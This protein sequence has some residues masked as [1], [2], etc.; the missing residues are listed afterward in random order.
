MP[1]NLFS[2]SAHHFS[3]SAHHSDP[4]LTNVH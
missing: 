1:E 4:E 3:V 2:G